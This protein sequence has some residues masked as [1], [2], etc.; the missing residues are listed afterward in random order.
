MIQAIW[1]DDWDIRADRSVCVRQFGD[2]EK[3][4]GKQ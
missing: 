3:T 2:M 1:D 4:G